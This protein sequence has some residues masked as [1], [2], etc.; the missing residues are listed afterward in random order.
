VRA[1]AGL[2]E[3]AVCL[4]ELAAPEDKVW[5]I[6]GAEIYRLL[7]PYCREAH[8]TRFMANG[9]A[10]CFMIDLA[11]APG[12]VLAGRGE[13]QR[14]E[15]LNFRFERYVQAAPRALAQTA[16]RLPQN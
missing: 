4:A 10:D 15:N 14:W 16:A 12:W 6:G 5:V 1:C 3:L 9:G 8:V 2:A 13:I 11:R 7:L